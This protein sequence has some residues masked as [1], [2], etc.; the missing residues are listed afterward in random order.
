MVCKKSI[1]LENKAILSWGW[2][3]VMIILIVIDQWSKGSLFRDGMHTCNFGIVWG[4]G[5]DL[6]I[7]GE[8]SF[9]AIIIISLY[10]IRVFRL[11]EG[12]NHYVWSL[13]L[14]VAGG[15][16]N[17][18][19]RIFLGCVRDIYPFFGWFSWNTADAYI[20]LGCVAFIACSLWK[21]RDI[22]NKT[23]FF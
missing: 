10:L 4:W 6:Q 7:W 20:T 18:L 19:D 14:I 16:G 13:T 2:L 23:N 1:L 5:S 12:A 22:L 3:F 11:N 8:L 17:F 9:I 15:A 21:Q